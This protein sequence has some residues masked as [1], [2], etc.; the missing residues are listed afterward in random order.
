MASSILQSL[1]FEFL[2]QGA[3]LTS[4]KMWMKAAPSRLPSN[5][6]VTRIAAEQPRMAVAQTCDKF[7][8][9]FLF[10]PLSDAQ[11]QLKSTV[12]MIADMIA[13]G[14][15]VELKFKFAAISITKDDINV[16]YTESILRSIILDRLLKTDA[17]TT[18]AKVHFDGKKNLDPSAKF[19]NKPSKPRIPRTFK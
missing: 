6:A 5:H 8:T 12:Q 4:I 16:T 7:M 9:G 10:I 11:L 15:K 1:R 19:A 3:T 18:D 2:P 13:F 14:K 17:G